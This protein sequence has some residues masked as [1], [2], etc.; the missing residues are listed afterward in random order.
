MHRDVEEEGDSGLASDGSYRF[1]A[2]ARYLDV[3]FE[4]SLGLT[5]NVTLVGHD[6]GSALGF[7]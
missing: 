1:T 6:W 5:E 4:A 3:L 2:H 7:Y